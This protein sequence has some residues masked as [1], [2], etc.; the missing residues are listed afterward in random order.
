MRSAWLVA[1]DQS[2]PETLPTASLNNEAMMP[3]GSFGTQLDDQGI[4]LSTW[5]YQSHQMMRLLDEIRREV[6]DCILF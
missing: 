4:Q 2:I 6:Y 3:S 1:G 5:F